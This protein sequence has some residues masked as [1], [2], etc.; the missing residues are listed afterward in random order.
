MAPVVS[1]SPTK[2]RP[3]LAAAVCATAVGT[4]GGLMTQLGPWY[5]ALHKPSWE[6]PD[7]LFGP[8]W[9]LIFACAAMSG[10]LTWKSHPPLRRWAVIAGMFAANGVLNIVW[11]A[12][13][14]RLHRPDLALAEV[15]ALW[16]SI[17]ALILAIRPFSSAGSWF[18]APYL[19]WVSFAAI[20]NLAIVRL[21]FPFVR[22]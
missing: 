19:A 20:L 10:A 21:N 14:F 12:L 4:V 7:W 8:A 16:L 3:I 11:S 2:Q 9:T 13:F 5:Y 1:M 15:L 17:A 22:S 6:P 18:L